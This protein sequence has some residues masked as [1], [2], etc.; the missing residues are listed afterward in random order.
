[1]P[2]LKEIFEMVKEQTEPDR[3][4]WAEHER[5]L[6]QAQRKRKY[7]AL[8]MVAAL[9]L[10]VV[11]MARNLQV[12][13][14]GVAPGTDGPS[15]VPP[16]PAELG[17]ALVDLATGTTTD[18]GIVP[19]R[20]EIDVSPDGSRITYVDPD[21]VV[22]VANVDGSNVQTFR[23]TASVGGADAPRWSPDG[24]EIVYQA[25]GTGSHIGNLD[26]LDVTSGRVEQLTDLPDVSVGWYYMAPTFSADGR[27]VLFT[28]P[29]VVASG[30]DGREHRWD[31]WSVP[32]TGGEPTLLRRN[33]GFADAEPR[34][35]SITFVA[36]RGG[37]GPDPAFGDLYVARSDGSDAHKILD[38]ETLQPRWSP[39]GSQIAFAAAGANGLFVTDVATGHTEEILRSAEWPEWV[40]QQTLIIDLSD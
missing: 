32:A 28:M 7:G 3:D 18:T 35:D 31:L 8:A 14:R 40:D 39:D 25:R 37:G 34:G 12:D 19:G 5:R 36:L 20:S 11:V 29:T 1:M 10:V 30:P 4:S 38:G 27:S 21:G 17:F 22:A 26:V 16:V 9:V 15:M 6:R 24:T 13:D 33:A 23:R 2:D